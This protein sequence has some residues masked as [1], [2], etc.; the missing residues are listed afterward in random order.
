MLYDQI[1]KINSINYAGNSML[2]WGQ[3]KLQIQTR[4]LEE[5]RHKF[6]ELNV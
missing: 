2:S 5:L 4:S 6:T 3:I 1:L